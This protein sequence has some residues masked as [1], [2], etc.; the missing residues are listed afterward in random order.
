[1]FI[2]L[3]F[4]ENPILKHQITNKSQIPISNTQ[5]R[6]DMFVFR[7]LEHVWDLEFRSS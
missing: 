4:I 2:S 1:M 3:H 6:F 7:Y 5:N